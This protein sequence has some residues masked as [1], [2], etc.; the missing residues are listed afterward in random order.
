MGK[1]RILQQWQKNDSGEQHNT[2]HGVE[3]HPS[4]SELIFDLV[5]VASFSALGKGLKMDLTSDNS[6]LAY[7]APL[8]YIMLFAP[9][10]NHWQV[11]D[12]YINQCG[13]EGVAGGLTIYSHTI[14]IGFMN[15]A[16]LLMATSETQEAKWESYAFY[17]YCNVAANVLTTL[18]YSR[19]YTDT[20][21]KWFA[22]NRILYHGSIGLLWLGAAIL[23]ASHPLIAG[24]VWMLI[25]FLD[26]R[27]IRMY[28]HMGKISTWWQQERA[29]IPVHIELMME[30]CSLLIIIAI[31]ECFMSTVGEDV[32]EMNWDK[33]IQVALA[34]AHAFQLKIAFFDVLDCPGE[35]VDKHALKTGGTGFV[36]VT[37]HLW[38]VVGV[39]L[40][41][42]ILEVEK[43]GEVLHFTAADDV[44][45]PLPERSLYGASVAIVLLS[46]WKI[47]TTHVRQFQSTISIQTRTICVW[48]SAFFLVLLTVAVPWKSQM[49]L[50][51]V[52]LSLVSVLLVLE[53]YVRHYCRLPLEKDAADSS[54][55]VKSQEQL[56]AAEPQHA[57][58]YHYSSGEL[59]DPIEDTAIRGTNVYQRIEADVP[60]TD[61]SGLVAAGRT[62][63]E[64]SRRP[65]QGYGANDRYN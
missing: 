8:I 61:H 47:S 41:A 1:V 32:S 46:F 42:H 23:S 5:I 20:E 2:S 48:V 19:V 52:L 38:A 21:F 12:G 10:F 24:V 7:S 27:R 11:V 65:S 55:A 59:P 35:H 33:A 56:P 54:A 37:T 22:S 29:R 30:R 16:V 57:K 50:E 51:F 6:L 40:S 18:M 34:A 39:T 58:E 9:V 26:R 25:T 63:E 45:I 53:Y 15:V 3:R 31:G 28:Y 36:W 14:T 13:L 17:C 64:K 43:D 4:W 60:L 49:F 44:T 62:H